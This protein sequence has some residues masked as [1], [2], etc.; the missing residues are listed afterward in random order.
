MTTIQAKVQ[1]SLVVL[2]KVVRVLPDDSETNDLDNEKNE[3]INDTTL[4]SGNNDSN[5][6]GNSSDNTKKSEG[7]IFS[8][9]G[10]DYILRDGEEYKLASSDAKSSEISF[11]PALPSSVCVGD[12]GNEKIDVGIQGEFYASGN[13]NSVVY[14]RSHDYV[15]AN[16][17]LKIMEQ[18]ALSLPNL[19]AEK[20]FEIHVD[21]DNSKVEYSYIFE[22]VD[23]SLQFHGVEDPNN[24]EVYGLVKLTGYYV[25]NSK[26]STLA[27]KINKEKNCDCL[28]GSCCDLRSRPYIFKSYRSQPTGKTDYYGCWDLPNSPT[29]TSYVYKLDYYCNGNDANFHYSTLTKDTC[30][31]CEYCTS[32]D[33]TCNYYS[34]SYSCGTYDCNYLEDTWPCRD[35]GI[36]D[37]HCNGA[38]S[39]V[40][41]SC[42]W[43]DKPKH[44]S[45][46]TN[47]ECDGSGSCITCKNTDYNYCYAMGEELQKFF[48]DSAIK[49]KCKEFII[50]YNSDV[51]WYDACDNTNERQRDCIVDD[52]PYCGSRFYCKGKEIW[53]ETTCIQDTGCSATLGYSDCYIS[54]W[55]DKDEY[56]KTCEYGCSDGKCIEPCTND[57][58][59]G[60]TRCNGNVLQTCGN[61]DSDSCLEWP[62]STSGSGNDNCSD[63]S[64]TCGNYGK[65]NEVGYCSDGKDNDCDG[66]IDGADS[67][68][69]ECTSG[70]CCDLSTYTYKTSG[71]DPTGYT[72]DTNGFCTGTR[73]VTSISYV[74]TRDYYC[75]GNDADKHYTDSLKDTCGICEDC[76]N[77]DLTCN[78]YNSN[79]ACGTYDC[80]YLEDT[81][82]CRDYGVV[83][84][85]CNGCGGCIHDSCTW[86]NTTSGTSCGTNKECDG[87]GNCVS[88]AECT[89]GACCDLSTYTYKTSGADPTGYTDDTNGLCSGSSNSETSCS[90]TSTTTCYVLTKNYYCNSK[91]A[92]AH[93]SYTLK[94][95]C[96]ICEYCT[97]NDLTCNYYSSSTTCSSFQDCDYLNNYHRTG[98]QGAISTSYCKYADYN[99]NYRYCSGAGSCSSLIC[100]IGSDTITATA[101]ICKYISGCSGSTSGTVKNYVSKTSCGTN[102]E[103]NGYGICITCTSHAYTKCYDNDVYWFDSCDNR[104]EKKLPDC[105]SDS[106]DSWGT[107]YCKGE[108]VYKKRICYDRGCSRG[109]CFDN[110]YV[111]EEKVEDCA[112]GCT[113]DRCLIEVCN[114]GKCWYV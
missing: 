87:S 15:D 95:T 13:L 38:G 59:S 57:C 73:G 69:S 68:C 104:E 103:C 20:T 106:C 34:S 50:C 25:K 7:E 74:Y 24:I 77:N 80:N 47:K 31:K 78:Y 100:N 48:W 44:T 61:Y 113:V 72:D 10:T 39:C 26:Y 58:T 88:V 82:P 62:S 9:N 55:T 101:G 92:D 46:G 89:S 67:D 93:V 97:N 76:T 75:N 22:D 86:T 79:Y 53:E 91:D 43:T 111:E 99:D 96:G 19:I 81:W 11:N 21:C 27:Y 32:G 5:N 17:K 112:H 8:R 107:N 49:D 51:Y 40:H 30:G 18:D 52:E 105:G 2:K 66:K 6:E 29:T 114:Y 85:H 3:S 16:L 108:D 60:Q 37:K 33:S 28:S 45:C 35:Y 83:D 65:S 98:T 23:L 12:S 42:T 71:A 36:V 41:D 63:C 84:K 94:D 110:T 56:K 70:P 109:A 90:S 1:V 102:K 54:S 4:D 64:C 14:C